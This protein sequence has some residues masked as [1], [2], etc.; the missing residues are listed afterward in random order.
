MSLTK[1]MIAWIEAYGVHA[2]LAS[3][4]GFPTVIVSENVD[5]EE[6]KIKIFLGEQQVNLVEKLIKENNYVALAP[7]GLGAVRAPY[8]FKGSCELKGNVLE[9]SVKEI[10][11]TKPGPEAGIRLDVLGDEGVKL[12]DESRWQ[13]LPPV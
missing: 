10:Y 11:C 8:Q 13:D 3:K 1:R 4:K 7:G 6:N 2:A 12:F 5:A 9:V